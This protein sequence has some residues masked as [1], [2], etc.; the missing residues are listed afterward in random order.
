MSFKLLERGLFFGVVL[1]FIVWE[2]YNLRPSK[3]KAERE[4]ERAEREGEEETARSD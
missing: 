3:L 2:V 1:G 4:A